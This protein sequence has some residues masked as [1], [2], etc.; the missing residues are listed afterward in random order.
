MAQLIDNLLLLSRLERGTISEQR[1]DID[2]HALADTVWDG[3]AAVAHRRSVAFVNDVP[4][5]HEV[6]SCPSSLQTILRNLLSNAAAYTEDGGQVRLRVLPGGAFEVWDSGPQLPEAQLHRV[7]DRFWRADEARTQATTHAG[8]G[9]SLVRE[10][11]EALRLSVSIENVPTGGLRF[12]VRP[13]TPSASA[14]RSGPLVEDRGRRWKRI[15]PAAA[16]V[17]VAAIAMGAAAAFVVRA[18]GDRVEEASGRPTSD[19]LLDARDGVVWTPVPSAIHEEPPPEEAPLDRE[20]DDASPEPEAIVDDRRSGAQSATKSSNPREDPRTP[21]A[22]PS[23]PSRS[24]AVSLPSTGAQPAPAQSEPVQ[25]GGA[26]PSSGRAPR[27][28]GG[29]TGSSPRSGSVPGP[30]DDGSSDA[31]EDCEDGD[32]HEGERIESTV[33][34]AY[35][36]L[37]PVVNNPWFPLPIGRLTVFEGEDEDEEVRIESTVLGDIERIEGAEALVVER[38]EFEDDELVEWSFEYFAQASDGTVCLLGEDEEVF[39]DGELVERERWRAGEDG[40][41]PGIVMP[42]EPIVATWHTIGGVPGEEDNANVVGLGDPFS[43]P[44]GTWSETVTT[45]EWN[46]AEPC[47]TSKKHYARGLGM[48]FDGELPLVAVSDAPL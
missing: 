22:P 10:L 8:I 32:Q 41:V 28:G 31:K 35:D 26:I 11:A 2:L 17:I 9:L 38:L 46:P 45:Q 20:A 5:G 36:E 4:P 27:G 37:L 6:H 40:A 47:V 7:F 34:L 39:E 29:A 15:V 42:A 14:S 3:V 23:Q 25:G 1:E 18:A 21:A 13:S 16:A 24:A 43:T 33:C 12:L 44:A 19:A 30:G 48:V